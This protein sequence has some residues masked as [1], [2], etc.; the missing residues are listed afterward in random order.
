MPA[1]EYAR[2]R[3]EV[4]DRLGEDVMILA[5]GAPAPQAHELELPFRPDSDFL[6][7]TG[8]PE[9]HAVAVLRASAE[10]P[11]TLFVRPRNRERETWTGP[12]LGPEEARERF[13]ADAAHPLARLPEALPRLLDGAPRLHYAVWRWPNLDRQV[14]RA[15]GTLR[16]RERFGARPPDTIVEPGRLLHELRLIKTPAELAL[17]ER[18]CAISEWGHRAALRRCR[19]GAREYQLQGALEAA[20]AEAGARP[21]FTTIV[22]AGANG[23]YLH[24]TANA[25]EIGTADLVLVDAGAEF[26]GYTGDITRTFPAS[27]RFTPAQR[28]LYEAVLA[29]QRAAIEMVRPGVTID[30]I[31][32]ATLRHL[33]GS[34]VE[35]G[36]LSGSVD[37][38]LEKEAYKPFYMH[39]TSHWLGLD[40]HDA[41]R[42]RL[43]G[44]ARP[45]A[46]G[47]V[48]TIEPGL[49]V[50]LDA[51]VR[52]E[53]RGQAVR[54]EDDVLV[55]GDGRKVLTGTLPTDPDE[56][57]ALV[58]VRS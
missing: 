2:R 1:E 45:L 29:A 5:A 50:A 52:E 44:R 26:G 35:L 22:A 37:E 38:L 43:E 17:I 31:H 55:T 53:L 20:Y 49:Y 41:G 48:F 16:A 15:L 18:A 40:V 3:R 51:P 47:M 9:P 56:I 7:V 34:L 25:S 28:D 42:Y 21:G 8:F 24:Y 39:R 4:L 57:A 30:E 36:C 46:A 23:C 54:I 27:G 12:R 33:T 6:Y 11:F 10:H 14:R 32:A 58:G 13:G 19:P